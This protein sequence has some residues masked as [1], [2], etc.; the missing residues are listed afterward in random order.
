MQCQICK[1]NEA[2]IHLTEIIDGVRS[3]THICQDCA[4][5]QGIVVKSQMPINELLTNLLASQP[6]DEEIAGTL[7]IAKSCPDCGFTLDHFRKE[8]M[9]GCPNDY[10]VFEEELKPL[11]EKAQDY[12]ST[13]CGKVPSKMPV[14]KKQKIEFTNLQ[15]ELE[16]AVQKEDYEQA[17]ILR[18]KIN[19]LKENSNK[20]DL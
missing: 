15:K 19:V 3:E 18:D 4:Q 2:T 11:I 16:I 5:H 20:P 12:N 6:D 13:H 1:K 10:E 17:A 14:T 9:L 7:G 8:A